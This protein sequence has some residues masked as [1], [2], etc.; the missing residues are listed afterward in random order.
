MVKPIALK[1]GDTIGVV[2]PSDAVER[3]DVE[4]GRRVVESW[5]L[6]V[7]VGKHVYAK[8]GDFTA[9]SAAERIEDL[10]T[11]LSDPDIKAVWAAGG[12]YAATEIL[13][14]L[15][16]E[17]IGTLKK[18]LKWFI[19]YS[20]VCL[21]LNALTSFGMVSV[22][23]PNLGGLSEWDKKS[24]SEIKQLLF[25]EVKAGMSLDGRCKPVWPGIAEGKIVVSNLETLIL[26]FG[27]RFDPLMYGGGNIILGLEEL[28]IDK[29]LLQRQIDTVLNHKKS[30]RIKGIF[31]GRLTNVREI[32][33][34][35]WGRKVT[36]EGLIAER[37]KKFGVP[38]VFCSD[39]GHPE[40]CYGS[41]QTIRYKF[42]NRRFMPLPN[43]VQSRLTVDEK[44]AKLE[45]LE[46]VCAREQVI[47]A[48]PEE[49][50]TPAVDSN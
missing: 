39:F 8:V 21:I 22:M 27:T 38:L 41:F 5:G 13:P 50:A 1:E 7:K 25:G 3:H 33:Y 15:N 30:D 16:K 9:G 4:A 47:A 2:A 14:V 35:E 29:S 48:A 19:G 46:D 28:D 6:K 40:W 18:N 11:M 24:Q 34:P 10:Q 36:G 45:I 17:T 44:E 20:D 37:V 43:G 23:G 42:A 49:L 12:G 32:S 26:S 31:I